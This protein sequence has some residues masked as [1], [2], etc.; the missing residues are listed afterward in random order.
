MK[1]WV[2]NEFGA[3]MMKIHVEIGCFCSWKPE[4]L[5]LLPE[6]RQA[7]IQTITIEYII[8]YLDFFYL[9]Q[10]LVEPP[11][12]S[13]RLWNEVTPSFRQ[14]RDFSLDGPVEFIKVS[15]SISGFWSCKKNRA[16]VS[17]GVKYNRM[18]YEENTTFHSCPKHVVIAKKSPHKSN[19]K[20][21]NYSQQANNQ[22]FIEI[23]K[24]YWGF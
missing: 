8:I 2:K 23:E 3:K 20:I 1:Q 19:D 14:P 9:R 11:L 18:K 10:N 16:G 6:N 5:V 13:I 22:F 7:T 17:E 12:P 21:V 4:S 15:R 24:K